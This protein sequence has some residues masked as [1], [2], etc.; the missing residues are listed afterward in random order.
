MI[1]HG[2]TE[3]NNLHKAQGCENDIPLNDKGREQARKTGQYLANYRLGSGEFDLIISSGMIRAHE[4]A[5]IIA[6]AV[7]YKKPIMIIEEFKEKCHG[8]L[9]G[10]TEEELNTDPKFKKYKELIEKEEKEPDPIKQREL[11][12]SHNKIM[13]ELYGTEL[14]KDFRKRLKNGIKKLYDLKEKKIIAVSH[15]GTILTALKI[16]ANTD[17]L[18]IGDYKYGTNCHISY[19]KL[20]EILKQNKTKRRA[21][22]IKFP[23]TLHLKP[24]DE[25]SKESH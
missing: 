11:Y 8:E 21:K 6:N 22:I 5:Q 10:K 14:E 12:Y 18:I 2:Q 1:R 7:G 17:D 4:T 20:Y 25:E 23:N 16:L 9:G 15:G 24:K 3:W 19:I 13:N